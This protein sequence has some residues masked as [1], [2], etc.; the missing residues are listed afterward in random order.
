MCLMLSNPT[1]A[2]EYKYGEQ[3][4]DRRGDSMDA[5]LIG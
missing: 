3:E 4:G 5:E 2:D 1:S